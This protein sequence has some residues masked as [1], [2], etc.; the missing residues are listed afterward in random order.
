MERKRKLAIL[1]NILA[2]YRLPIF[3]YLGDRFQVTVLYSGNEGNRGQWRG[4]EQEIEGIQ[5]KQSR[6]VTFARRRRTGGEVQDTAYLHVTPGLLMDLLR[7][8]PD[9]I[10]SDEMG[11]RTLA[12]LLYAR[13]SGK[14][15]WVW[16]GGTAHTEREISRAKHLFRRWLARHVNRWFSYGRTSTEYLGTLGVHRDRVV[17][18]QNCVPEGPYLAAGDPALQLRIKPV[19]LCVGQ[20]I[21]RKGVDLLLDSAARLQA[22]GF[23]FSLLIV[24]EG[25]EKPSLE[26]RARELGLQNVHFHP[27]QPPRQMPQVYRSADLF[28]FPTREDVW[29]LVVNEAL[30]SGL[31]TLV[32]IYAGCASELVT[33]PSTFDPLD[34]VDFD[35]KL[36]SALSGQLPPPDLARLK[37]SA[38]VSDTIARELDA[39]LGRAP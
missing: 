15:V 37:T 16:W 12:A 9:A 8:S 6:G 28:V 2:P 36:R 18:L 4:V 27:P 17:E 35:R 20:L 21:R 10:V 33:P 25:P 30:W 34:P 29:G 31:P 1:T 23:R 38:E 14:P 3:Q 11:F 22:E 39:F 7:V 19:L 24:G 32:S 26:Q 5:I 13:F